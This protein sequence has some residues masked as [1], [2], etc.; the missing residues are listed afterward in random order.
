MPSS[1]LPGP[2]APAARVPRRTE[3]P[4]GLHPQLFEVQLALE[5][6]QGRVVDLAPI[7]QRDRGRTLGIDDVLLDL[8]VL[9]VLQASLLG[10][11]GVPGRQ[12]LHAVAEARFQPIVQRHVVRPA[13]AGMAHCVQPEAIHRRPR[14]RCFVAICFHAVPA[15]PAHHER[16]RQPLADEGRQDDR[17]RERA[18]SGCAPGN[19]WAGRG[20]PPATRRRAD[21]S[22]QRGTSAATPT[23]DPAGPRA[24]AAS[25]AGGWPGTRRQNGCR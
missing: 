16:E 6:A 9:L 14:E 7:A 20:P 23:S 22:T 13:I 12:V 2:V 3:F 21:R 24:G 11:L 17:E 5:L 18:G 19:R 8:P 1:A 4:P 15:E 10:F 25:S